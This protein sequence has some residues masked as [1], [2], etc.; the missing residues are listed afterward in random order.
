MD[1]KRPLVSSAPRISVVIAVRDSR[2]FLH[3]C[4]TALARS[5]FDSF[6]CIVVDDASLRPAADIVSEFGYEIV[7][8]E[9]PIGP[10]AARNLGVLR[11]R[12]V[13]LFF[14]DAD[15]E[16][17]TDTLSRVAAHF[18]AGPWV[19]AVMG[20]YDDSPAD[21]GFFSQYRNLMHHFVHQSSTGPAW[22]FWSACGAVRRDLF[23]SLAGFNG[24]YKRP[25]IEDIE[26]GGRICDAGG[27]ILLDKD[28][29]VKHLKK[30]SLS[31]IVVSDIRDRGF[32]WA[33]L[34][35]ARGETPNTL[36]IS[37][38][39]RFSVALACGALVAWII[40]A[41]T[42]SPITFLSSG[43]FLATASL[44]PTLHHVLS[45][46]KNALGRVVSAGF[47]AIFV[48]AVVISLLLVVDQPAGAWMVLALAGVGT[49]N[50]R[51]FAFF[52]RSRGPLFAVATV[53]FYLLHQW[54]NGVSFAAAWIVHGWRSLS[55]ATRRLLS[56]SPAGM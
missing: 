20:S 10:A 6:E 7:R 42:G 36:N 13:V 45:R 39:Q 54:G 27:K 28:L 51:L 37:I 26:F 49:L 56:G 48:V 34:L 1:Y 18:D 47:A 9:Q 53:P 4:L 30:W 43:I 52:F 33:L 40:A 32:P 12:G 5:D 29:Q 21:P 25:A 17:R 50:W 14:T 23:N 15:V 46:Y 22:T 35:A 31:T 38:T 2:E 19:A 8:S 44:A 16:V 11:A 24:R 3:R 41:C 55:L